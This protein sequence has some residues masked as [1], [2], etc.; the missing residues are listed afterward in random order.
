MRVVGG[1]VLGGHKAQPLGD[2]SEVL[3]RSWADLGQ[4]LGGPWA[5][6]GQILGRPWAWA[7][8]GQTLGIERVR[9]MGFPIT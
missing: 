3:G 5:D 6:L 4:T 8:L 1:R 7:D 9:S 2:V